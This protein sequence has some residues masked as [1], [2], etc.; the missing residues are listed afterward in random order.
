[1]TRQETAIEEGSNGA[2]LA[3]LVVPGASRSEITGPH[4]DALRLRVSAAPEKG[5]ANREAQKLLE[6]FF[7][8]PA[9][10]IKGATAR[11]KRFHLEADREAIST[12]IQEKWG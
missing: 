10:L 12:R 5:R 1:M 11:R 8:V 9:T 4:G 3:V 7:G 2:V 6:G